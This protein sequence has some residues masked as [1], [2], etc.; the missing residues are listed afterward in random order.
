MIRTNN[1]NGK[2]SNIFEYPNIRHTL[3]QMEIVLTLKL[4]GVDLCHYERIL[5]ATKHLHLIDHL[6]S[7]PGQIP[8]S[9]HLDVCAPFVLQ[10]KPRCLFLIG[11]CV[12]Y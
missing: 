11:V 6:F 4:F 3:V 10:S 12:G 2:Y 1:R 9:P 7:T 8:F 5:V